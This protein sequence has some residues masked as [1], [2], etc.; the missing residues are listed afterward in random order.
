MTKRPVADGESDGSW[1]GK[2]IGYFERSLFAKAI[3]TLVVIYYVVAVV[4][5]AVGVFDLEWHGVFP[6]A[7]VKS[8]PLKC[9]WISGGQT[10]NSCDFDVVATELQVT[11]GGVVRNVPCTG[12]LCLLPAHSSGPLVAPPGVTINRV[13]AA[14]KA[15]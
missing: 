2:L 6:V 8:D 15:S 3:V 7:Q 14:R 12:S 9:L 4:G 5:A 13:L 10:G 1:Q 11:Q